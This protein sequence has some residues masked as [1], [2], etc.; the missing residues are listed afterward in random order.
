MAH[1]SG[2]TAFGKAPGEVARRAAAAGVPVLLIAGSKAK[3]WE[4]LRE[5]GV[6]TIQVLAQEGDNL[7]DLMQDPAPALT[8][9]A[10]RA[11]KEI[12][13]PK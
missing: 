10:A 8:Q 9:V 1:D 7:R 13:G 11:V 12:L 3:G 6:N 2:R 4:S 5:K